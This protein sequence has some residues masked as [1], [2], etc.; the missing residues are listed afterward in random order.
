MINLDDTIIF[1][2][3]LLQLLLY[4]MLEGFDRIRKFKGHYNIKDQIGMGRPFY[5]AEIV[6]TQG[7]IDIF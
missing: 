7:W 4:H 3:G 1:R 6:Q 5:Y 2:M